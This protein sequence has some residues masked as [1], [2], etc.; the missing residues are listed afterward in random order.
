LETGLLP[1]V[2]GEREGFQIPLNPPLPKGEGKKE[3]VEPPLKRPMV[4]AF[5]ISSLRKSDKILL[6]GIEHLCYF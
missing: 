3:G 5:E 6:T 2:K 4:L 1:F